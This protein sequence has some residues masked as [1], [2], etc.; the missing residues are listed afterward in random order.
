MGWRTSLTGDAATSQFISLSLGRSPVGSLK[1]SNEGGR[2]VSMTIEALSDS[3]LRLFVRLRRIEYVHCSVSL[4]GSQWVLR[5]GCVF[6][7]QVDDIVFR[8]V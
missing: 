6:T 5:L 2:D 8:P 1:R 4:R 7:A 3:V